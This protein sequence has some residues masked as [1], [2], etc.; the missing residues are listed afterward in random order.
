MQTGSSH[1]R[2]CRHLGPVILLALAFSGCGGSDQPQE[3]LYPA[4]GKVFYQ[5][6][7]AVGAMVV[8]HPLNEQGTWKW[9]FPAGAVTADGSVKIQLGQKWD[10]APAGEYSIVVVWMPSDSG[11]ERTSEE[12]IVDKLGGRYANPAD[13]PWVVKVQSPTCELPRIDLN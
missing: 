10:G 1:L 9:G 5:G 12:M 3:T 4:T 6:Q 2:D 13:S 7:P 8:M 11:T